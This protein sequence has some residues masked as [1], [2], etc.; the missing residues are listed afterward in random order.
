M[1]LTHCNTDKG[2]APFEDQSHGKMTID[3]AQASVDLS[4]MLKHCITLLEHYKKSAE[5]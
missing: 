3:T 1:T 2:R 5:E 4:L